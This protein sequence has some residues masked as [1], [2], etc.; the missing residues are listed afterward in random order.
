MSGLPTD[1]NDQ[2]KRDGIAKLGRL[3]L[4]DLAAIDFDRRNIERSD[5]TKNHQVAEP[6]KGE[7]QYL[8]S[9]EA[10]DLPPLPD[11]RDVPAD[12]SDEHDDLWEEKFEETEK[13]FRKGSVRNVELVLA[14]DPGWRGV[15][16]YCLFSYRILKRKAAP[17]GG[18]GDE[19]CD[20]DAAALRVWLSYEYGF[21]PN[22]T[23]VADAVSVVARKRAFHPVRDYLSGLKWDGVPR[24]STW[25]EC[26]FNSTDDTSYLEAVGKRMLI[27]AVA[28]VM[29]PGCKMDTVMILEGKQGKGKSTAIEALFGEFFTDAP[30]PIGDKDAYQ[31]IQ[32]KWGFELAELDS[33]NKSESTTLK[34]FFSQRIDRFRPSYGRVA[35]DH[36]RQVVFFGSTNQDF[37]FRDYSGNRR[38]W[39]VYCESVNRA[40]VLKYRDQLWAEALTLF[41]AGER[42][43]LNPE[44]EEDA[45]VCEVIVDIQD[46]RLQR[47]PW[48]DKLIKYLK[49]ISAP[50]ITMDALLTEGLEVATHSQQPMHA[51]RVATLMRALGWRAERKRVDVNGEKRQQRVWINPM[52]EAGEYQAVPLDL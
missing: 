49:G 10:D 47:D 26:A 11:E 45:A 34:H 14:N 41:K 20:A 17:T 9:S 38:F 33:F 35:T 3:V 37:Y 13:G 1:F 51:N 15:L 8:P 19:W 4:D 22:H 7:K 48:E 2:I 25:L 28:R 16:A 44:L 6:L 32:G 43:W 39:P 23:D 52:A 42:W 40:W 31:V 21:T 50:W 24:L 5:Q 12:D 29:R 27:G 36:P 46:S 18:D 30:L